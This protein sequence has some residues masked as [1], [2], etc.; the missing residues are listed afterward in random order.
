MENSVFGT[1]MNIVA[2]LVGAGLL[3]LPATLMQAGLVPGIF[4]QLLMC[5]LNTTSMLCIAQSC[6]LSKRF[7][8]K[9]H[10]VFALGKPAAVAI[11]TVMALYTLGSLVSFVVLI[12][13]NLPA[14]ICEDGCH[15]SVQT[16]FGNRTVTITMA[17][18]V[19]LLPL[20]LL[21]NLS[22]L[23]FTSTLS[24]VCILY[25]GM[26]IGVRCMANDPP[27]APSNQIDIGSTNPLNALATAPVTAVAY[28]LHYNSA[29]YYYE[30]KDRSMCVS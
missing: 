23:R 11:T 9:E 17:A 2:N 26:M 10:G 30:L 20:S 6:D 24:T 29:R 4:L 18:I 8:F 25:I 13:D 16:V 3:S 1:L 14:L 22:G 15:G 12:G 21:R 5:A 19:F 7:T 28:C 27:R